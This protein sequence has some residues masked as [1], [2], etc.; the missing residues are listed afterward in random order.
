VKGPF[1]HVADWYTIVIFTWKENI[2]PFAAR[3]DLPTAPEQDDNKPHMNHRRL[4]WIALTLWAGP[5]IVATF[6]L[7]AFAFLR[8]PFLASAG[9]VILI[10]GGLCLLAGVVAVLMILATHHNVAES[11][12]R[13][14]KKRALEVLG[15]LLSNLAV[16]A[17]YI[18]IGWQLQEPVALEVSASPDGEFLAEVVL[19]GADA[20]PPY[21]EAVTLRPRLRALWT[22]TRTVV[23]SA[24]CV[25][26]PRAAWTGPRQLTVTCTGAEKIGRRLPVFREVAIRYQLPQ[27]A[28]ERPR[29]R[30]K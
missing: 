19:L 5:L 4:L 9:L 13:Y 23:F 12:R 10:A 25:D 29:K 11:P 26:T 30:S 24:H 2:H 28:T 20:Q 6:V 18:W 1:L 7:L 14:Y 22:S 8:T 15:L 16:A 21:G 3:P 17:L 27:A